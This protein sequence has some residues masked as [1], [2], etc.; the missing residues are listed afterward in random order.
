MTLLI[1]CSTVP[2]FCDSVNPWT[3]FFATFGLIVEKNVTERQTHTG[4][5]VV[6]SSRWREKK[7]KKQIR[8]KRTVLER[9]YLKLYLKNTAKVNERKKSGET[10]IS[11]HRK[12]GQNW[13]LGL[14]NK[15]EGTLLTSVRCFSPPSSLL[16]AI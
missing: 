13:R 12:Q 10:A 2:F 15:V 6:L 9:L 5:S 16:Q 3:T 8:I 11:E 4:P 1:M 14:K 7:H